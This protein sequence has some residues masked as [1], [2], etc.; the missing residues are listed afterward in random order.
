M[1]ITYQCQC[2]QSEL[3]VNNK[4]LLRFICHCE[5]CQEYTGRD[6]SD[7]VFFLEKDVEVVDKSQLN[8]K[9]YKRPPAVNRG[10]CMYCQ[11]PFVEHLSLPLIPDLT[12]IP[13]PVLEEKISLP[14]PLCH[15]FYH[16]K[17]HDIHD[18]IPKYSG[19]LSSQITLLSKIIPKA[20]KHA[21]APE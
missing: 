5:I 16:K 11:Q 19:F 17:V 13:S 3:Q 9:K 2:G 18:D 7:V 1:T 15:V 6:F 8:Y 20:Y 10:K 21:L 4:P 12:L 14:K